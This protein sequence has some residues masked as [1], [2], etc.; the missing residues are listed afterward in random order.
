MGINKLWRL[1]PC[2][3]VIATFSLPAEA[4]PQPPPPGPVLHTPASALNTALSCGGDVD[5]SGTAKPVL[6]VHGTG[7]SAAETWDW[8]YRR[9]LGKLNRPVCVLDLPGKGMDDMQD[10]AEYVVHAIRTVAE[11]SGNKVSVVS[12]DQGGVLALWALRF[13]PDIR[14]TVDDYVGLGVP[15]RGSRA[16]AEHCVRNPLCQ[17]AVRQLHP[18][19]Q[20]I[21]NANLGQL[22][23]GPS[24]TSIHTLFDELVT[25]QPTASLLPEATNITT[26]VFCPL[27]HTGH[28][29]LLADAVGYALT[30]DALEHAGA[31]DPRRVSG[32][33]CGQRALPG[34]DLVAMATSLPLLRPS[35]LFD[36]VGGQATETEPPLRC[37]VGGTC[38]PAAR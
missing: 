16:A 22:P 1:L 11:R 8:G 28:L 12:Y 25:P 18:E 4:V 14:S 38:A 23:P 33:L 26:Q 29:T 35:E 30:V 17:P 27:R 6:L 5:D 13:W 19:S 7:L 20:L 10:A 3:A 36:V 21:R 37:Y 34:A 2:A 15:Y 31:A 24:Y 32:S 9:A